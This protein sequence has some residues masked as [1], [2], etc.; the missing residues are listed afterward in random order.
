MRKENVPFVAGWRMN[1]GEWTIGSLLK[2][3][4]WIY[5]SLWGG[6]TIYARLGG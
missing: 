2:V 5:E 3:L 4:T 6:K 1:P